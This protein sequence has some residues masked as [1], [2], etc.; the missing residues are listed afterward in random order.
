MT[1]HPNQ[2]SQPSGFTITTLA[3]H[4]HISG[5]KRRSGFRH[6]PIFQPSLL[7]N[8]FSRISGRS[9]QRRPLGFT[10]RHQ[11]HPVPYCV[12]P[13]AQHTAKP[14][15]ARLRCFVFL[16]VGKAGNVGV[17]KSD[18]SWNCRCGDHVMSSVIW[19]SVST[20]SLAP[21][22][23]IC[24]K[25]WLRPADMEMQMAGRGNLHVFFNGN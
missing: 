25:P 12:F 2:P 14:S 24:H 23:D 16:R 17:H 15:A 3:L 9:Y 11:F 10:S 19:I 21:G 8:C 4:L 6:R 7:V 5:S 22:P 18:V 13:P 20:S 1:Y